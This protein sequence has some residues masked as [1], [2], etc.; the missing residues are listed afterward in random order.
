VNKSTNGRVSAAS[1]IRNMTQ[2][3][4]PP[5]SLHRV[6]GSAIA[7]LPT[8]FPFKVQR[9]FPVFTAE[10]RVEALLTSEISLP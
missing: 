2:L 1:R 8:R 7:R 5:A 6:F 9:T 4:C 10:L 3:G